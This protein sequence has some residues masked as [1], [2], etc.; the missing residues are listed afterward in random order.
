MTTE[1]RVQELTVAIIDGKKLPFEL[2]D[3]EYVKERDWYLR[4]YIDKEGGISL[5]DCQELSELIGA[6]LDKNDFIKDSYILEV[7]SPGLDRPLKKP[8][9][10][11]R[12][13]GKKVDVTLYKPRDGKKTFTG[14]LTEKTD[15]LLILDEGKT[16]FPTNEI[17][18]VRLHID[19]GD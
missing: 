6:E 16:T 10:F 7:S 18:A 14:T 3:V 19:I 1:E 8:A 17:A 12:E 13:K 15:E 9:D 2:V 11:V 4:I 5:D